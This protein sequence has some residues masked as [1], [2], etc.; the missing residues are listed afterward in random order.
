MMDLSWNTNKRKLSSD[1]SASSTISSS[2]GNNQ[3]GRNN[4]RSDRGPDSPTNHSG[5]STMVMNGNG[6]AAKSLFSIRDLV[7]CDNEPKGEFNAHL[8]L[9]RIKSNEFATD[10]FKSDFKYSFAKM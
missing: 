8:R 1:S 10:L 3:E 5:G 2:S 7:K 9:V 6:R 4:T